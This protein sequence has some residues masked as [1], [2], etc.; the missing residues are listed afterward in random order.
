MRRLR[1][2]GDAQRAELESTFVAEL[3]KSQSSYLGSQSPPQFVDTSRISIPDLAGQLDVVANMSPDYQQ[4]YSSPNDKLLVSPEPTTDSLPRACFMVSKRQYPLL[5][6]KLL[7]ARIVIMISEPKAINGMFAVKKSDGRQRLICDMRPGGAFFKEPPKIELPSADLF[8]ELIPLPEDLSASPMLEVGKEDIKDFFFRFAAPEWI[9]PFMALRAIRVAE[10][11]LSPE[12]LANFNLQ[13]DQV[14]YPAF[15]VCAM[16]F[17]HS[18]AMTQNAHET[19]IYRNT[20]LQ[21]S[22]ALTRFSDR[23]IDRLRHAICL[24]DVIMLAPARLKLVQPALLEYRRAA[25]AGHLLVNQEK[26]VNATSSPVECLGAEID[27]RNGL[28]SISP[29]RYLKLATATHWLLS[30][31]RATGTQV[32]SLVG[33]WAWVML[34]F[35]PS[36]SIF[37]RVYSFAACA[38]SRRF[39]LWP[40]VRVELATACRIAPLLY[41]DL[42]AHFWSRTIA[43]DASEIAMGVVSAPISRSS[44]VELATASLHQHSM[45]RLQQS[46]DI[47]LHLQHSWFQLSDRAERF[48]RTSRWTTI[49]SYPWQASEHINSLEARALFAAVR[50]AASHPSGFNARMLAFTDSQV[51]FFAVSKGR[52]SSPVLYHRVRVLAAFLLVFGIR[53]RLNWI[54]SGF[55]PADEPSRSPPPRFQLPSSILRIALEPSNQML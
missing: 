7:R 29:K 4:L 2:L 43:C 41:A 55:N 46:P 16:G 25:N 33:S 49:I 35:R 39:T 20:S 19:F 45:L 22:N 31:G 15:R 12:E 18:P 38:G 21:R 44:S 51:V 48:I 52:S 34:L 32:S 5:I 40:S 50:W 30:T 13:P 11:N 47:P 14:L 3:V 36:L 53:L 42:R 28:V 23:R 54:R 6:A 17:S 9:I 27:G 1:Q 26:S 37:R 8:A 10:L 24:D